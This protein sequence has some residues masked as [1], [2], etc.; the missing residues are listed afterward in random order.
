MW[1]SALAYNDAPWAPRDETYRY[2]NEIIPRKIAIQLHIKP[3]RAKLLEKYAN[4]NS[5]LRKLA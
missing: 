5:N 1:S 2:V 3:I 4:P